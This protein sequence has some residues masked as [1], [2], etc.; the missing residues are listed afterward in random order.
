MRLKTTLRTGA[1]AVGLA[2]AVAAC[3]SATDNDGGAAAGSDGP[4]VSTREV[5][6]VGTALTAADGKTLYF[7]EQEIDG[8]I[9]CKDACLSFWTPLTVSGGTKP[10]AGTGVTGTLATV[11]RPDGSVQVTYDGK[12]LYTFTD[13][14]GSGQAKGNGVKDTFNDT[15]F[16]W[17]A[18]V[19]SGAAPAGAPS[20]GGYGY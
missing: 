19:A 15:D 18:A 3:G 7:A 16:V 12:P 17:R 2:L 13:D 9:K 20:T 1:V 8:T 11:N 10:T 14:G 5:S 4:M 6:G